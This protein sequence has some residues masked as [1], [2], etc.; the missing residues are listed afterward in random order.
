MNTNPNQYMNNHISSKIYSNNNLI[1]KK[2][3]ILYRIERLGY[4]SANF[5]HK[6]FVLSLFG[7]I[8]FNIGFF[9]KE[10]NSY[11]RA[12][13]VININLIIKLYNYRIQT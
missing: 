8:V 9:I 10:Y 11:W 3:G 2:G 1:E 7:F 6:F 4:K 13:R 5:A 12:R